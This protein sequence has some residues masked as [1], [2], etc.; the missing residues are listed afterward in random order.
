MLSTG[1]EDPAGVV[2]E[3]FGTGEAATAGSE[4][5]ARAGVQVDSL[6]AWHVC[7]C[8]GESTKCLWPAGKLELVVRSVSS[9]DHGIVGKQIIAEDIGRIWYENVDKVFHS[10]HE[11]WQK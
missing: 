8:R 3:Q 5:S 7:A 11:S 4:G 10:R 1:K 9:S 2:H 6:F